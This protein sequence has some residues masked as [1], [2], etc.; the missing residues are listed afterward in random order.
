[1][2]F[3]GFLIRVATPLMFDKIQILLCELCADNY[4]L[5]QSNKDVTIPL[6]HYIRTKV[7]R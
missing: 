2:T 1:M 5:V 7:I 3:I 4:V 6:G